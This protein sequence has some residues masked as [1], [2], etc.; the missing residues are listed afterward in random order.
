MPTSFFSKFKPFIFVILIIILGFTIYFNSLGGSF[1]W[2]DAGLIQGNAYL[3][4]WS[5]FPQIF[6]KNIWAGI[7]EG[8]SIWRPLQMMTYFVDYSLWKL[9]PW[10]YHLTNILL[11]LLAA[12][13]LY[14]FVSILFNNRILALFSSLLFIAHPVHVEAVSY[15][16]GRADSLV[17]IFV[18][19]AFIFYLKFLHTRRITFW[20]VMSLSFILALFTRENAVIF[21]ALL[22]IYH[23]VFQKKLEIKP[24]L[25]LLGITV[26]YFIFRIFSINS[27]FSDTPI[28]TTLAQRFPGFLVA[29]TNYM[30][31]LFFPVDL[32]M[33]YG[34]R[35]FGFFAPKAIL[36]FIIILSLLIC[37]FWAKNSKR[38]FSFAILWFFIAILPVS[39]LYPLNAYMAEHWLYL[40]SIGF[41]MILGG[42]LTS[43]FEK[44]KFK[45]VALGLLICL[46]FIYASL[47]I[48]QN[49]YWKEEL[50]FYQRTLA[51]SPWSA[52]V[53]NNLGNLYAKL[54][55]K[56]KAQKEYLKSIAFDPSAV[57]AYRNLGDFYCLAG[58]YLE[59][60]KMY[61]KATQIDPRDADDYNNIGYTFITLGRNEEG[62]K[63]CQIALKLNPSSSRAYYNLG[64]A[65]YNLR[66]SRKSITM[67]EES[68]KFDPRNLEAY[69]NL[70]SG[71]AQ[72]GNATEA[73][74]LWNKCLKLNPDFMVAHFNLAVFYFQRHEYD[75][76]IKHCDQVIALGAQVDGKFLTALK[77]FRKK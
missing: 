44:D 16:S 58:N 37:V 18:L 42:S 60:I 26:L 31:I 14:W 66:E 41:F 17:T 53:H 73:I 56:Y 64:N 33:E 74:R 39:N 12:L 46:L 57:Y 69:N 21:P 71:Y 4:D 62:I 20:I 5:N 75:L 40:P 67:L 13:A 47:T 48:R 6:T 32:H 52:K 29:F 10:G 50:P 59:G 35:L 43:F 61:L 1:I 7:G 25:P 30:G 72:L 49:V 76:A 38:L 77:P 36:G 8:S 51:Y 54:G 34:G 15:I 3:K 68:V 27:I 55:D 28:R 65:Y 24:F 2:D 70:A 22:I 23:F 63:Y 11:H 45:F 9:D 19:V